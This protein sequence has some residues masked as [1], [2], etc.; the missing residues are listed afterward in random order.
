[1]NG[2][3]FLLLVS[4][5]FLIVGTLDIFVFKLLPVEVL[6]IIYLAVL[7]LPLVWPRLAKKIG[8]SVI[9]E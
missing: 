8:V 1:M 2:G 6:Q 3:I 5:V 9:W 7:G 4:A